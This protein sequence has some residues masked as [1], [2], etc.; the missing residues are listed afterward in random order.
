MPLNLIEATSE[1]VF[2]LRFILYLIDNDSKKKMLKN[3]DLQSKNQKI[4]FIIPS[5][6]VVCLSFFF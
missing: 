2:Y 6:K 5:L 4:I 1:V 3:I